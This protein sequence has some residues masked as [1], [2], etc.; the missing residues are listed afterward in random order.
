MNEPQTYV[1]QLDD[2]T[3]LL[4]TRYANGHVTAATRSQPW[5]TWSAPVTLLGQPAVDEVTC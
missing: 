1:G 3:Y 5:E 4:V 2:G